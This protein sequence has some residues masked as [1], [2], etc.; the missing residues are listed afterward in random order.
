MEDIIKLDTGTD[1]LIHWV[2]GADMEDT[3]SVEDDDEVG[4]GLED[5]DSFITTTC[6]VSKQCIFAVR[7][8]FCTND[9]DTNLGALNVHI[10]TKHITSEQLVLPQSNAKL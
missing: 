1:G 4:S 5:N 2:F 6:N 10:L 7:K 9:T 3:I 8:P